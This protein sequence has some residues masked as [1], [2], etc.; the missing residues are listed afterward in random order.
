MLSVKLLVEPTNTTGHYLADDL[1]ASTSNT[2]LAN[3]DRDEPANADVTDPG[4]LTNVVDRYPDVAARL[5]KRV[6]AAYGAHTPGEAAG[7]VDDDTVDRLRE[8]GYV[9]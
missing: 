4:E 6:R 2:A 7:E 8:L 5:Q 3:S 1:D 9:P